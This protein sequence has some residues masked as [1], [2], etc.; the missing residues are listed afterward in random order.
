M[1]FQFD[2][3]DAG[4]DRL[5]RDTAYYFDDLTL[6]KGFQYFKQG[7]V[8]SLTS[9]GAAGLT[10]LV[11]GKA[12]YALELNPADLSAGR[13]DCPD[14]PPCKHMA[15]ALLALADRLGRPVLALANA[16]AAVHRRTLAPPAAQTG[17]P[18]PKRAESGP[19][20]A[21][22]N[23]AEWHALFARST[24]SLAQ[25]PRNQE[26]ARQAALLIYRSKPPMTPAASRLFELHASLYILES[27]TRPA[28]QVPGRYVSRS[29]GY[30]THLAA[31]DLQNGI[32]RYLE[33][34]LPSGAEADE[35]PRILDTLAYL[36]RLMLTEA[37]GGAYFYN[38]YELLW[39][40]WLDPL[41]RGEPL[42]R[43]ELDRLD[44]AEMELGAA[45]SRPS[46]LMAR[47][48]MLLRLSEDG[49]AWT[50]LRQAAAL[51]GFEPAR[52]SPQLQSLAE[53]GDWPRLTR[54]LGEMAQL[55]QGHRF[56]DYRAYAAYWREAIQHLP[57][58]EPQ[59]WGS[60]AALLPH[61]REVYA[62][63]LLSSGKWR[64]WMDFQLSSGAEPAH[65]RVADLEPLEKNAPETLLPFYHQ[66]VERLVAEKNRSSYKAAV[67]LLKRLAKLYHKMKREDRWDD[68]FQSF[69]QQH[70][71]LRALQEELRKG[72]LI[73]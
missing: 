57:E 67:R 59:M 55:A 64:E 43:D 65:F 50:L 20:P 45:L 11:Q 29:L 37:D 13:C 31:T 62:E 41:R 6:K 61:S 66:A 19:P 2:L 38:C 53:A 52:L 48:A 69:L 68:F 7:R 21:A 56:Y 49:E 23:V 32:E 73:A 14:D 17:R 28:V 46:W 60:L 47:V 40:N 39:S 36:R 24:S 44:A 3:D 5:L 33:S 12:D 9:A 34:K 71:R 30:H 10:A 51:P 72:K 25:T 58:K 8:R 4:W 63:L 18:A 1:P 15:A 27:L 16:R 70:S 22:M 26:Y 42:Y 35:W 54:W